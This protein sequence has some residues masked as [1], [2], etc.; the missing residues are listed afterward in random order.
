MNCRTEQLVWNVEKVKAVPT[1]LS[2]CW[3]I[4]YY[5]SI[6]FQYGHKKFIIIRTLKIAELYHL[7]SKIWWADNSKTKI[8]QFLNKIQNTLEVSV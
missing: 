7:V 4:Y 8:K 1:V 3:S 5:L 2:L 6:I